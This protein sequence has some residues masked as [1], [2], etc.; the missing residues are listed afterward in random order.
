MTPQNKYHNKKVT[1]DNIVFDSKNEAA[2]YRDYLK[3][4]LA[5]GEIAKIEFHPKYTLVDKFERGNK[6]FRKLT[7]AADF[8]IYRPDGTFYLVDVKGMLTKEFLIKYKLFYYYYPDIPLLLVK[9]EKGQ[10]VT[11]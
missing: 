1:L 11:F 2:Y 9:K 7:Y 8:K 6:K 5:T 10:W 3:P 4:R